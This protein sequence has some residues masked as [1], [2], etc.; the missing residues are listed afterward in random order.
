[1]ADESRVK[2]RIDL[3]QIPLVDYDS[4]CQTQR[5]PQLQ[6]CL[7]VKGLTCW[8][9]STKRLLLVVVFRLSLPTRTLVLNVDVLT[10]I[11]FE[12][13]GWAVNVPKPAGTS[14]SKHHAS[15]TAFLSKKRKYTFFPQTS[16][17]KHGSMEVENHCTRMIFCQIH[18]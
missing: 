10:E 16:N 13:K 14:G 18:E 12:L 8:A 6:T 3:V 11:C 9:V 4:A 7:I 2:P 5:F 1:M 17:D 15:K